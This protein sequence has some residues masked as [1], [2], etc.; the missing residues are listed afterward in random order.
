MIMKNFGLVILMLASMVCS[1]GGDSSD[2]EPEVDP[3]DGEFIDDN[4]YKVFP[5]S[6]ET[7]IEWNISAKIQ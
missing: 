5:K 2:P 1:C 3:K 4:T 6:F 7:L